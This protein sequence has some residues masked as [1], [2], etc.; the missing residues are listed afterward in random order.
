MTDRTANIGIRIVTGM[1]KNVSYQN[2]LGLNV[3]NI[4]I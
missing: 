2:I 1:A 3:L 4:K